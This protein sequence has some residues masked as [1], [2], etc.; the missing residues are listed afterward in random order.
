MEH[1]IQ[2]H[3]A[4]SVH[5][6]GRSGSRWHTRFKVNQPVSTP[7]DTDFLEFASDLSAILMVWDVQLSLSHITADFRLWTIFKILFHTGICL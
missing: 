1:S 6:A 3:R 7:E 5:W 4:Q 2:Q